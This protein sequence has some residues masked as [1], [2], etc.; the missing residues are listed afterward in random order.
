MT[1]RGTPSISAAP[2]VTGPHSTPRLRAQPVAQLCLVQVAGGLGGA[3]D[4]AR[5]K[6][7]EAAL[8]V[9]AE[10]GHQ[11]VG[12]QGRIA[13][14]RG[15]VAKARGHQPD[16]GDALRPARPRRRKAACSSR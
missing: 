5:V 13:G 6:G 1:S 2:L 8:A 9:L 10:V 7:P 14:A 16:G 15:A 3:V 12:V 11:H 4:G